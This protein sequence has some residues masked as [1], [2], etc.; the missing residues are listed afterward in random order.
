[1]GQTPGGP[2]HRECSCVPV[3]SRQCSCLRGRGERERGEGKEKQVSGEHIVRRQRRSA[4]LV[5]QAPTPTAR[6]TEDKRSV[7]S[8]TGG[9]RELAHIYMGVCERGLGFRGGG[10]AGPVPRESLEKE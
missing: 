2:S 10:R 1:M 6:A 7:C 4:R 3:F 9:K 8:W 5:A